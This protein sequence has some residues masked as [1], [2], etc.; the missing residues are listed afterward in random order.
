MII[1]IA[2][3]VEGHGEVPSLPILIRRIAAAHDLHWELKIP[4]PIRIAKSRLL[5][6]GELE[7]AVELAARKTERKGGIL[8]LLDSDG[9]CPAL[10]SPKLASRI[11][12]SHEDLLSAVVMAKCEFESWFLAGAESL[13][14]YRGFPADLT[15]PPSPESVRGAKEWLSRQRPQDWSYRETLDQPALSAVVDLR[16]ISTRSRSFRKLEKEVIRLCTQVELTR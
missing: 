16:P 8:I 1:P 3:I 10:E 13:R 5:K 2:C 7:R 4:E 15:P 9:D 6:V 12:Q 14:G 11:R